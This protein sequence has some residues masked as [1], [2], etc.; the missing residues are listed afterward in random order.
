MRVGT[1]EC[2]TSVPLHRSSCPFRSESLQIDTPVI[3]LNPH[4]GQRNNLEGELKTGKPTKP[5]TLLPYYAWLLNATTQAVA[6][7]VMIGHQI[8][9]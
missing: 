5:Y 9:S 8:L 3:V 6:E 4:V 7:S 1:V 2:S